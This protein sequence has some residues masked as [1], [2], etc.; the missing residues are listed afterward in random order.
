MNWAVLTSLLHTVCMFIT[1]EI[2]IDT[3]NTAKRILDAKC[4]VC[5]NYHVKYKHYKTHI[6]QGALYYVI[7]Y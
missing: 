3:E 6:T 1:S 2:P 7:S 4:E 5:Y